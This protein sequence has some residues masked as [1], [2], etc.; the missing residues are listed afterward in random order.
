MLR[1]VLGICVVVALAAAG[2][3]GGVQ[4]KKLRTG[5]TVGELRS[6][7]P[8]KNKR[9]MEIE[10]RAPGEERARR[11]T[12]GAHQKELLVAVKAASVGDRV[13]I[14]WFDTVEG[15]CVEKFRVLKKGGKE[16]DE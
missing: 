16:A 8:A 9:D 3:A 6:V 12:V 10:V 7:K 4:L 5:S 1:K 14:D 2:Q 15:L 13:E 11:Y